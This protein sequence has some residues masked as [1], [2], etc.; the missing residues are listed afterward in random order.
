MQTDREWAAL[1]RALDRPEWLEDPRFATP[2]LRHKHIDERLAMT[3]E[4]LRT[5][6]A[7]EWLER[8]TADR[9]AVRAGADA[10]PDDRPSAGSGE[11][12]RG[13][14]RAPGAGRLRQAR[15]AARFSATPTVV[16]RGAPALGE[17][18]DEILAEIGFAE[19]IEA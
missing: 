4:V 15:P 7:A 16:R 9:R 5:R 17:H 13:R 6:P 10:Q 18:T 14:D 19:G 1:T 8:L 12:H 3:Q 11:R 2:A